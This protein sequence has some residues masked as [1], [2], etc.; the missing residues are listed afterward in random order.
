MLS[1]GPEFDN[2]NSGQRRFIETARKLED[3][4]IVILP[5]KD[6]VAVVTAD[7]LAQGAKLKYCDEKLTISGRVLRGQS[8][9]IH[10]CF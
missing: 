10:R 5:A 1:V 9:A 6:N 4:A 8:F 2:G 7:L 3:V